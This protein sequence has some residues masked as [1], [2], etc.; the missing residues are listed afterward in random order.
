M[1]TG[2]TNHISFNGYKTSPDLLSAFLS[3]G[4]K[5]AVPDG[6]KYEQIW[7]CEDMTPE[8][9]FKI[10]FSLGEESEVTWLFVRLA[11]EFS[12]GYDMGKNSRELGEHVEGLFDSLIKKCGG[13]VYSMNLGEKIWTF[14]FTT[15]SHFSQKSMSCREA[16]GI[17]ARF[18]T[19][20]ADSRFSISVLDA[21]ASVR[22]RLLE[23]KQSEENEIDSNSEISSEIEKEKK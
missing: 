16:S 13:V 3:L 7:E 20:D 6:R 11:V 22:E 21:N 19:P 18:M 1:K 12:D 10:L 15:S 9:I 5:F 17:I 23:E 8:D 4:K 2:Y 14:G